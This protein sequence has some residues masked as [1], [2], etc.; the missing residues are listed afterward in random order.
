M[1]DKDLAKIDEL[2]QKRISENNIIL[3]KELKESATRVTEDIS[4]NTIV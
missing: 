2:L 4:G 3:I 1:D